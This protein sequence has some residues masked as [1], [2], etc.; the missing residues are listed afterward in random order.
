MASTENGWEEKGKKLNAELKKR[1]I[2]NSTW[3]KS[4]WQRGPTHNDPLGNYSSLIF[5]KRTYSPESRNLI[6]ERE[7]RKAKQNAINAFNQKKSRSWSNYL[8]G[9]KASSSPPTETSV[10]SINPLYQQSQGSAPISATVAP[11]TYGVRHSK[12]RNWMPPTRNLTRSGGKRRKLKR[13]HTA[14]RRR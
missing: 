11:N 8:G 4:H 1:G 7:V 14:K 2:W 6:N 13:R 10:V 12:V 5:N 3:M 9:T